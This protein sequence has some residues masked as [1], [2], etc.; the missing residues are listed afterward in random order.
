MIMCQE[1]AR[2]RIHV[3]LITFFKNYLPLIYLAQYVDLLTQNGYL[4]YILYTLVKYKAK[5]HREFYYDN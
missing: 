1:L 3:F 4:I 2:E 5:H